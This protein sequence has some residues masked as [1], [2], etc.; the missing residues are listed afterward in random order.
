VI[1]TRCIDDEAREGGHPTPGRHRKTVSAGGRHHWIHIRVRDE[2]H[3]HWKRLLSR[4][5][6]LCGW[7]PVWAGATLLLHAAVTQWKATH[8]EFEPTEHRILERDG[9]RCRAPGC[10]LRRS[11][12]VPHIV[13]RSHRGSEAPWNKITLCAAHHRH[14]AHA[15]TLRIRGRAPHDLVWEVGIRPGRAPRW[16]YRGDRLQRA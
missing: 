4:V 12:E 5:R 15:G 13:F 9:Y 3:D 1:L 14:A 16:V 7:I 8:E 10:S 11:L 2:I 6:R